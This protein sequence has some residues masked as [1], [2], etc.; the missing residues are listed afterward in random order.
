[1]L[2][3]DASATGDRLR[4]CGAVRAVA[5]LHRSMLG[6]GPDEAAAPVLPGLVVPQAAPTAVPLGLAKALE[7]ARY[8]APRGSVN[9]LVSKRLLALNL[10][11]SSPESL[12]FAP[13]AYV[14]SP[15][16]ADGG[17]FS[18]FVEDFK[19][20]QA[21]AIVR[22]LANADSEVPRVSASAPC[23]YDEAWRQAQEQ[24]EGL[25]GRVAPDIPW[26]EPRVPGGRLSAVAA[27]A[28]LAATRRS[29]ARCGRGDPLLGVGCSRCLVEDDEWSELRCLCPASSL[30]EEAVAAAHADEA[31]TLLREVPSECQL[32]LLDRNLWVLKPCSNGGGNGRGILILDRLPLGPGPLLRW[33]AA[34]GRAGH[35][36]ASDARDGC[37][38]QKLVERP[39]LMERAAL[40]SGAAPGALFKYNWRVLLNVSLASPPEVW[41]FLDSNIDLAAREF[42]PSLDPASHVTNLL[43]G[44]H[45]LGRAV[46]QRHWRA[47]EFAS[48]LRGADPGAAAGCADPFEELLLPQARAIVRQLFDTLAIPQ[49]SLADAAQGPPGRLKRLGLDF[50]VDENLGLWLMEVNRLNGGY[51]LAAPRGSGGD[52]KREFVERLLEAEAQLQAARLGQAAAPAAFE[53]LAPLPGGVACL[54]RGSRTG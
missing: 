39:H 24:P 46:F 49:S 6:S 35:A 27:A 53:N 16:D 13:R 5:P 9:E 36:G 33:A 30:L 18:D 29:L 22:R 50:L 54:H 41:L 19:L 28:A 45:V 15:E 20:S 10:R 4:A 51:G 44:D 38:L 8:I 17:E 12:A 21:L 47:A 2:G 43:R 3:G 42:S 11:K 34:V 25:R 37:L 26:E 31:K 7:A 48:A 40:A 52:V 32:T 23:G 1:M 14:F